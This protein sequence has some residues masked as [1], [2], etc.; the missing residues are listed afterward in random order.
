[1]L[2][3]ARSRG[4][5]TGQVRTWPPATA[6]CGEEGAM[7][8]THAQAS[9]HIHITSKEKML[10]KGMKA[11]GLVVVVV[12][13]CLAVATAALV[14]SR[15][16]VVTSVPD[17]GSDHPCYNVGG[18]LPKDYEPSGLV[19]HAGLD[20]LYVIS[21][22]GSLGAFSRSG[23]LLDSWDLP[24][25]DLEGVTVD[26]PFNGSLLFLAQEYPPALLEYSLVANKLTG[27]VINVVD[28][29]ADAKSG[30]EGVT[31]NFNTG[32]LYAGSQYDGNVYAYSFDIPGGL[33]TPLFNITTPWDR[34]CSGLS[35]IH[36]RNQIFAVSDSHDQILIMTPEGDIV[37][38]TPVP[39]DGQEGLA[40]RVSNGGTDELFVANDDGKSDSTM[41]RYDYPIEAKCF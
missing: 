14:S 22:E 32:V 37:A 23:K 20:R 16:S 38:S 29:P 11:T 13:M 28:F 8:D 21:D 15:Q 12:G 34:D 19:W 1:M 33:L 41:W 3:V 2:L 24:A 27:R 6:R 18:D 10:R 31:F 9:S 30:M 39:G 17:V 25:S 7:Q 5:G 36:Q 4:G 35:F 40:Y 26:N